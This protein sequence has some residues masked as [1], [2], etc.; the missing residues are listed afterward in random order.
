M[1]P[2]PS[3]RRSLR[4]Q[5]TSLAALLIGVT[6][7]SFVL[8][9]HLGPDPTHELLGHNPSAEEIA[10]L[11]RELGLDQAFVPRYVSFLTSLATLDLGHS[12]RSGEPVR[13]MLARA[14][15]VTLALLA[16][17]ILLGLLLAMVGAMLAAWHRGR[18]PAALLNTLSVASMSLSF[19]VV[20]IA[21]QALFGVVLGWFPVRGWA[22]HN[23]LSYLQ[24]V[25]VPSLA[26]IVVSVGYNLRFMHALM[27]N[28]LDSEHVRTA[29]A[30]GASGPWIM[31]N[32]V[33]AN[34]ALPIL[35]RVLFTLPLMLIAGSLLLETHFGIPGLGRISFEAIVSGDQ[36]VLMAIV[37][38][39]AV[40][41]AL[42]LALAENLYRRFDPRLMTP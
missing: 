14:L 11:R 13:D 33:L 23:P 9:V 41:Y 21:A 26:L 22:V 39:S 3:P 32:H 38:L 40:L 34:C 37:S 31:L 42:I 36:P 8:T 19:V 5:L 27:V 15:P 18:W 1:N 12:M 10:Q 6:L 17:G 35:T 28:E 24:A 4:R 20:I 7:I 30:F 2:E 29:R 25:F 16:P